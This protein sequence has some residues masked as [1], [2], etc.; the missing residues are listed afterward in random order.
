M[1]T[2]STSHIAVLVLMASFV[3]L[4]DLVLAQSRD[5]SP[6]LIPGQERSEAESVRNEFLSRLRDHR[7]VD[8]RKECL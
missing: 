1:L 6:Q 8:F 2:K 7:S 4:P 5:S 3:G